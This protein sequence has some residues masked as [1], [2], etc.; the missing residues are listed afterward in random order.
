MNYDKAHFL[1][2][3]EAIPDKLWC[4]RLITRRKEGSRDVQHCAIGHLIKQGYLTPESTA[5]ITLVST[6]GTINDGEDPRYQQPTP[7]ARVLAALRDLP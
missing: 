5:L 1:A 6:V 4:V 3:F 7:R 2:R